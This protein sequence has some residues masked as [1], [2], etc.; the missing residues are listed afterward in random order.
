M[1]SR[2]RYF[3][4]GATLLGAG[5]VGGLAALLSSQPVPVDSSAVRASNEDSFVLYTE[6]GIEA[7]AWDVLGR[8]NAL[9]VAPFD[10]YNVHS[11]DAP[12]D[13]YAMA[14][15]PMPSKRFP[16]GSS[17]SQQFL[18]AVKKGDKELYPGVPISYHETSELAQARRDN[19]GI[20]ALAREYFSPANPAVI[21]N[22][23]ADSL[24]RNFLA[25]DGNAPDFVALGLAQYRPE[26]KFDNE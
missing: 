25:G 5:V 14:L 22:G 18:L 4:A 26:Y 9:A 15:V 12:M 19:P 16:D 17:L 24:Y 7:P 1:S 13:G 21:G 6:E 2:S 20:D 23:P 3:V 11:G 10:L 8:G